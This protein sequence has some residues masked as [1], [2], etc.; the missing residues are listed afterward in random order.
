MIYYYK[1]CSTYMALCNFK[2]CGTILLGNAMLLR[3][4]CGGY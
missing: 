1:L 2:I 3:I 4:A